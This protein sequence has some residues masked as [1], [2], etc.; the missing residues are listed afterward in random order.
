[1]AKPTMEKIIQSAASDDVNICNQLEPPTKGVNSGNGIHVTIPSDWL[2]RITA[3]EKV[4]GCTY[5][6]IESNG[7]LIVSDVVQQKISVKAETKNLDQQKVD[8]LVQKLAVAIEPEVSQEI[9]K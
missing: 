6:S 1:M 7:S 3:G 4:A 8:A 5:A 2:S 9:L